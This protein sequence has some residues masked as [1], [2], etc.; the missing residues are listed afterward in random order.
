MGISFNYSITP[1]VERER[2]NREKQIRGSAGQ[3][4]ACV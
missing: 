1:A 2:V 3:S 4:E